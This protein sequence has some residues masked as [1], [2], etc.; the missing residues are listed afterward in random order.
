M[1]KTSFGTRVSGVLVP[2]R[3]QTLTL[4]TSVPGQIYELVLETGG[5]PDPEA[6]ANTLIRE[7]PNFDPKSR[8]LWVES[9]NQT[10]RLQITGSPF[11]WTALLVALPGILGL[12]GIALTLVSIYNVIG[13][14]PSWAWALLATSVGLIFLSPWLRRAFAR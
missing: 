13:S 9:Y 4:G 5:I 6:T 10:I 12:L 14:V 1:A 7:I 2:L 11:V 8:V 3:Q